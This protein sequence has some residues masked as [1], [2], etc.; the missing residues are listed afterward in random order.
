M[1]SGRCSSHKFRFNSPLGKTRKMSLLKSKK[2]SEN[3]PVLGS[4]IT[5]NKTSLNFDDERRKYA[6]WKTVLKMLINFS[7]VCEAA[8][9]LREYLSFQI[10]DL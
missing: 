8:L 7:I 3:S 9:S 6:Y 2:N 10:P 1:Y 5:Q 4:D